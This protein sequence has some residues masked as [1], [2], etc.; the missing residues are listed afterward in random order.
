MRWRWPMAGVE[1]RMRGDM[2]MRGGAVRWVAGLVLV[3][4]AVVVAPVGAGAWDIVLND[5]AYPKVLA[6]ALD[7]PRVSA[8]VTD[9]GVPIEDEGLPVVINAFADTGASGTVTSRSSAPTESRVNHL[10]K[11]PST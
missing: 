11:G 3:G 10:S 8:V 5:P 4:W 2:S 1:R 9:G 6:M 7:Q